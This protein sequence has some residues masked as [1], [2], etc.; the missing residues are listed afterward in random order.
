MNRPDYKTPAKMCSKHHI[1]F[2]LESALTRGV[3]PYPSTAVFQENVNVF[4]VF[5]VVVKLHY[6]LMMQD[7]VKLDF[8][9]NL[10]KE[11]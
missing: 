9:V 2:L 3:S 6:V 11:K 10:R 1:S 5:K 8:F 7:S 4:F